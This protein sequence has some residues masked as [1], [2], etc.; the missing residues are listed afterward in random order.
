VYECAGFLD[1][2][3]ALRGQEFG[4]VRVLGPLADA[5]RH[6]DCAFV[7][8]IGSPANF[9]RK[10]DI[11]RTTG[12]G[13]ER[14][15]TIIHPKADVSEFA[16]LGRGCVLLAGAAVGARVEL[17]AHVILLQSAVVGHDGRVGDCCSL[18]SGAC[19]A[20]NVEMGA[21]SYIG[22]N[23]SVRSGVKIGTRSLV[24]MGSVV[25]HDVADN[26]VVVG[27]PAKFLRVLTP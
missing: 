20:G 3:P 13:L 9:W 25:L 4:G 17:G 16:R 2:N 7:N 5:S 21:A 1:D 19:L 15:E 8:G 11:I 6:A 24:G 18:A 23:A 22:A 14:F 26:S 10:P 27:N 12:L